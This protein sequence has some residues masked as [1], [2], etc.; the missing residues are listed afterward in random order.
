MLTSVDECLLC[1]VG[2]YQDEPG[3]EGCKKCGSTSTTSEDGGALS[4]NC[5]GLGRNF[6]KSLGACK[7]S[8]G[9]RP[10]NGADNIDSA[11]DCEADVKPV[12]AAGQAI[13]IE[14]NCLETA[15]DEEKYCS[16]YCSGGGKVLAGT[17]MCECF[18][19]FDTDEICDAKCQETKPITVINE[20]GN[21]N[22][23]DPVTGN[24]TYID[25][26]TIEGYYGEFKTQSA[27]GAKTNNAVF[28][29][30]GDDF[31]FGFDTNE[32]I[33]AKAGIDENTDKT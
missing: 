18:D 15:D 30:V 29:D 20:K 26:S 9:Y 2:F 32:D 24:S 25:P 10:K 5:I 19:I 17:G 22:I 1:K 16:R 21:L 4:C 3:Q 33:L 12:C 13:T 23:T 31:S 11:E 28:L 8:K 27:S 6:I 14:G 7:C